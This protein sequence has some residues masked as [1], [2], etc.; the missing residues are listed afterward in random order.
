MDPEELANKMAKELTELKWLAQA[1]DW[2]VESDDQLQKAGTNLRVTMQGF[3]PI[4]RTL[5][6]HVK[7]AIAHLDNASSDLLKVKQSLRKA[8]KIWRDR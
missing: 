5:A 7:D 2:I 1:M 3:K 8:E 6:K 4:D